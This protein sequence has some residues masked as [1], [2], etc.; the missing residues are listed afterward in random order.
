MED[1]PGDTCE[2]NFEDK[3]GHLTVVI[4]YKLPVDL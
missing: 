4:Y 1:S 2:T 3:K